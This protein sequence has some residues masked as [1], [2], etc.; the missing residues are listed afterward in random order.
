MLTS[1]GCGDPV[2]ES[3]HVKSLEHLALNKI[4]V[5]PFTEECSLRSC[6]G[7]QRAKSGGINKGGGINKEGGTSVYT[8][9]YKIVSKDHC[10]AHGT[11]L[12]SL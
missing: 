9:L 10:I 1:Q 6:P 2:N 4:T 7:N 5:H 3:V 11:I 12:D 8:L